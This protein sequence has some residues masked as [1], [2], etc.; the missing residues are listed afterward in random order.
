[1]VTFR[2]NEDLNEYL[3]RNNINDI[4]N[5]FIDDNLNTLMHFPQELEI[6]KE[7]ISIGG[8]KDLINETGTTPI[9]KQKQLA[10][11]R[12]LYDLGADITKTNFFGFN[13][14]HYP[15]ESKCLQYLYD[16]DVILYDYNAMYRPTDYTHTFEINRLLITGG[17][18]PYNESYFSLPGIFLQRSIETIE[19]YF[20]LR[21]KYF[22]GHK[23]LC[24]LCHE[25]LL[26]KSCINP[27]IIRLM[28][29]YGENINHVNFFGNN[30]L[31][32]HHDVDIIK[33]L[34]ECGIDYNHKNNIQVGALEYHKEKNN[35]DIYTLLLYW[36]KSS[37][38]QRSFRSWRFKINYISPKY[39]KMKKD[40]L[41]EI[42]Y[43]PPTNIYIGGQG[44]HRAREDFILCL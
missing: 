7:L 32:L 39:N 20:I 8:D 28:N 44:Y 24:D 4:N 19:E 1:M 26:F 18:D 11:V 23:D 3:A 13:A 15:K 38:I 42:L 6:M 12:Y 40:V 2:D 21:N 5:H 27:N 35:R 37:I 29:K 31:F 9:M 33:T 14:F 34:L 30:A 16:K 22:Q 36:G 41:L 17:Y 25:T 43:S 10:T